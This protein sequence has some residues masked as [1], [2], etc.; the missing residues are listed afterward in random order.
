VSDSGQTRIELCGHIS[1]ELEGRRREDA[2]PG[3]QGRLLFAYLVLNRDRPTSRDRLIDLLWPGSPPADPDE[4]LSAVLSKLRRALGAETLRGRA[5]LT[6]VLPAG[7]WIDLEAADCAAER[8]ASALASR[9]PGDAWTEAHAA[10]E[11]ANRGFF[12]RYDNPWAQERSEQ[13]EQ[14]RLRCLECIAAA[15]V[16]LGGSEGMAAERAAREVIALAPLREP[17][18]RLLMGLLAARG[19]VAGALQ[20]YE[21]LRVR[22]RDELGIAPG[23]AAR[24]LHERLLAGG[25]QVEEP[26]TRDPERKVVTVLLADVVPDADPECT[27]GWLERLRT[28]AAS[29]VEA[30]GGALEAA[31]G[32]GVLVTF[33]VPTAREDHARRAIELGHTLAERL[34]DTAPVRIAI[35]TGEVIVGRAGPTGQPVQAATRMLQEAEAGEVIIGS[36]ARSAARSRVRV[37][38]F[39]GR[40]A[41]I[42]ALMS[43]ARNLRSPRLVTIVGDAGVGKSRLVRELQAQLAAEM[44][45]VHRFLGRCLSYGRGLTYRALG[46]VL[47]AI[48]A[49]P[50]GRLATPQILDLTVGLPGAGDLH[51]LAA[52]EQLRLAWVELIE[53]LVNE[54]PVLLVIEDLHWA[55]PDL[56][57][58]LEQLMCEVVGPLLLVCTARPELLDARPSWGR[59]RDA[60]TLWLEPL[61]PG[62]AA[63]LVEDAPAGVRD[64]V[65]E[66]AEGNPFFLE[67]MMACIGEAG[68]LDAAAIP[69]SIHSVLAARIDQ[70]PPLEKEALQAAS[71]IGRIFWREAV[72]ALLSGAPA[73]FSLLE[74]RD[75]V[76]PRP[77]SSLER[78]RELTFKH[79]LT[80]EV[81]YGT[82]SRVR[83]AG[84]HGDFARWL[85]DVGGGRDEHAALL[86]HHYCEA[87]EADSRE[88]RNRAL[89]WLRRSGELA[90]GRYE[91]EEALAL[92]RRALEL[93]T[94]DAGRCT[95]YRAIARANALKFDGEA[96][97]SAM[98]TAAELAP[99]DSIRAEIISQL[100]VESFVRAGMW[101]RTP[102]IERIGEWVARA[103]ALAEPGSASRA[104]ALTAKTSLDLD[105]REAAAEAAAIAERLGD[106]ELCV[107]AWDAC[108]AAAM[109]ARDYDAAW[110]WR[111]RRL[112]LLDRVT[113]PDLRTII[114]ET[115]YASCVATARF[116]QAR[117]IAQLHD[118]LTRPLTPHHR[119]H[120]VAILVEVEELLGGWE[121]IHA[122]QARVK[123]AVAANAATPCLRNARSLLVCALAA[124]C[125]GDDRRA[126]EL[127]RAAAT[128]GLLGRQ[129]L[130]APRLRLALLRGDHDRAEQL[131]AGLLDESGWYARG[132]GTSLATLTTRIDALALL[133]QAERVEREAPQLLQPGAYVEPFALRALGIARREQTL[134][135]QAIDRFERLDLPWHAAQTRAIK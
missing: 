24:A 102:A 8:A 100:A 27:E 37:S 135:D 112:E 21:Q 81:A 30:R 130:D 51:P 64:V 105:D 54:R 5:D 22:L 25:D 95:T 106:A 63:R 20:V 34:R 53:R 4:S 49:Q 62:D 55:Q 124:A 68:D 82:L 132:H 101:T 23:P 73:S 118:E 60:T 45:R 122:Q 11:V 10:L 16:A 26:V 9:N 3:R 78:A 111:T 35:E 104:R 38:P 41:D 12:A 88:L 79:A 17:A 31:T 96:F 128:L 40:D 32:G 71:V 29:E 19:D 13:V 129:V 94:D 2:L 109:V 90:T 42:R 28:V 108:G 125:L 75:F 39:V 50:E 56:L 7:A 131:L 86:A 61:E 84:L 70:L 65:L 98:E 80:H 6:L 119:M 15:G 110:R 47:S 114:G 57:D 72:E 52:R 116:A 76:R 48:R 43:V 133:G 66:R 74:E 58:L 59:R 14:L 115:P 67:E 113:D 18:Y 1:V 117:E 77:G 93:E 46:D 127:E 87:L 103:L 107:H 83:R 89:H 134:I 120:G 36:R 85:E 121:A 126:T 97:W 33:G 44:P 91:I 123:D 99:D 69:D 92:L